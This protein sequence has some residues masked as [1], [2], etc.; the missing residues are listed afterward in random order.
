M[1]RRP[2]MK[3]QAPRHIGR[4][5]RLDT[6]LHLG[7]GVSAL[8][9]ALAVAT[10][11]EA[12]ASQWTKI[13]ALPV[14]SGWRQELQRLVDTEGR[15][16]LNHFCVVAE[17]F[18]PPRGPG[19]VKPP[20]EDQVGRVYWREGRR[21]IAWDPSKTAVDATS[22]RPGNDLDLTKDVRAT[23]SEVGSSTYLVTRSWV[24]S[25]IRHCATDGSQIVVLKDRPG[26]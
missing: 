10:P 11:C 20:A 1:R 3:F 23:Q 14:F 16:R 24:S 4:A 9:L 17:T 2:R 15:G 12:M 5:T 13:D 8:S 22:A 18:R 26:G 6:S 25:I 7:A 21:L 19:D